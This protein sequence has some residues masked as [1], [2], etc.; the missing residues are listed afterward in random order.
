MSG[1][2]Y[3]P[4]PLLRAKEGVDFTD[5]KV[6]LSMGGFQSIKKIFTMSPDDVL[7]E[8]KSANL[9][10]RGGA[11]FPAGIKW[12]F[13]P[14]DYNGVKYLVVNADEGEP[15]TFKD[16]YFLEHDPFPIIEGAIITSYAVGIRK[17][18]IY[19]RGEFQK[20]IKI[21][22]NAISQA[23]KEGFL[24]ENIL[25]SGFS[26][27]I[28]THPGAGAYIC[29]EETALLESI[30]GK[31]GRPRNRPPFPA[32]VGLFG[33]PTVIQN[34]ETIANLP[35]I[36]LLG[37]KTFL[38]MGLAT[39]GGTKIFCV[40]GDV[41]KPGLY[42]LPMGTP[43]REIIYNYAGGISG[44]RKLKAV[45]PG[46]ISTP[47]LTAEEI[48]VKMDFESVRKAGSMFGSGAIIVIAEEVCLIQVLKRISHFYAHES[49]GQC[50]PCR[51]GTGWMERII[52]RFENGIGVMKDISLLEN[53]ANNILGNTIC[54]LGDA[55]AMPVISFVRKFPSEFELHIEKKGCPYKQHGTSGTEQTTSGEG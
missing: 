44:G 38:E 25:G 55:A 46:G 13:I 53:I 28:Y 50:T 45:I 3:N 31:P 18:F 34:V 48:D 4:M 21:V 20:Q 40:S 52:Q 27:D 36:I 19:I 14:K 51:V 15:G 42:E 2:F 7:Q 37:A 9:R 5:I 30:E 41:N 8:V 22:N 17:S 35:R 16:R 11:G 54:A 39:D 24:G 43:L 23:Y 12:G 49:C 32:L 6:H 10:G 1:N 33:A 47:V 29:G 26:L